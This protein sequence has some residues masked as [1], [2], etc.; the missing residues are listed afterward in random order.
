MYRIRK[1]SEIE[2]KGVTYMARV[3]GIYSHLLINADY[4]GIY[5]VDP[6]AQFRHL[7]LEQ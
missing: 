7:F 5:I 6:I 2:F 3:R 1:H 4:D